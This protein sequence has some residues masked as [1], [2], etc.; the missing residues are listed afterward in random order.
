MQERKNNPPLWLRFLL[1]CR[2]NEQAHDE[3]EGDLQE[4]YDVYAK[5]QGKLKAGWWYAKQVIGF[6]RPLPTRMTRRYKSQKKLS[7]HQRIINSSYINPLDMI[8]NFLK[9]SW[10]RFKHGKGFSMINSMGLSIALTA[11]LLILMW[12][13]YEW[14]FDSFHKNKDRLY[15]VYGLTAAGN[16]ESQAIPA[17]PE[18]LGPLVERQFA[19]AEATARVKSYDGFLFRVADRSF[20][21]I[22]GAWVDPAFL[23]MFSFPLMQGDGNRALRQA[24]AILITGSMAKRLFGNDNAL[25]RTIRIDS[26][27]QAIV[28]GILKDFPRDSR[29]QFE[30][31]L[32]W[33][34]FE[35]LAG[36]GSTGAEA[37]LRNNTTTFV[38]LRP[39]AALASF[40]TKIRNLSRV[41]AGRNDIWTH[42]L[43][44]LRQWHLYTEFENGEPSGGLINMIRIFGL[45]AGFIVLIACINFMNLSTARSE[46][47]AKEIG[48]R[49]TAGASRYALMGQFLTEAWLTVSVSAVLSLGITILVLPYFNSLMDASL[50]IPFGEWRFW[51]LLIA[52]VSFTA[53]LAGC[54]P[55][56]YLS[57]FKPTGIFRKQF[58]KQ[59]ASI[60][61]R[62]VMVVTQFSI[63]IVLIIATLV[64]REQVDFAQSRD[65]G[66]SDKNLIRVDFLG[67]IE[68]NYPLIRQELLN[69][70]T[71][72]SVSKTLSGFTNGG[73]RSWGFRWKAENPK[74][75]NTAISMFSADADMVK[76]AGLQLLAGRDIDINHYSTDSSAVLI[77]ETAAKLMGFKDP[78]GQLLFQGAKRKAWTI[79]GVVKDFV[80]GSPFDLASPVVILGPDAWFST[81][82]IRLN[83]GQST[84]AALEKSAGVFKKYNP[85]YPFAYNFVDREYAQQFVEEQ[86]I[87]TMAGWFSV[88]AIA[89][90]CL[91]L[92][93]LSAYLAEM[94][95]K[96][97]AVRKVLG[98]SVISI[99]R[100]LSINFLKLVAVAICISIPVAWIAM[101]KWL[102]NYAYRTSL[103][104][105]IFAAAAL[106]A[107]A[108]A[109]TTVSFQSIKAALSNPTKSLHTE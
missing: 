9:I 10:R 71:A 38:Q 76:T 72:I 36:G 33:S 70:G 44:P 69:S 45:I 101:N 16:G 60:T 24:E 29:F 89:I 25:G 48:V 55:A 85:A 28:T 58:R 18:P 49:K 37:W 107:L 11:A 13:R 6:L 98:A 43:F 96:E 42:F 32:P 75:T 105:W 74:D 93:G 34:H 23:D 88:L 4:L 41:N 90:S 67:D 59:T 19:E 65:R 61:P 46:K 83:P 82:Y 108:I 95:I 54:Y 27:S 30:F 103:H 7:H 81:M 102:E 8:S 64:I 12:I 47:R 62:Q 106:L 2:L 77:N 35:R 86:K 97:I 51:I 26:N 104:W 53:L 5:E 91:G 50:S 78:V 15:Q 109:F 100:L 3:V 73:A 87:K 1:R 17:V 39:D 20:T 79:V 57:A 84:T 63:A 21:G 31:L 92:F 14:N 94:R 68:K 40:N 56:F 22:K 52:F 66:Y 99:S 80:S